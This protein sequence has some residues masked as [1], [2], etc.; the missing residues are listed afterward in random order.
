MR[1][2][3]TILRWTP[4]ASYTDGSAF[5]AADFRGYEF[6]YRPVGAVDLIPVVV[7]V[8]PLALGDTS[9]PIAQLQLPQNVELEVAMRVVAVNGQASS[10]A[11]ANDTVRF[12]ARVPSPP[13]AVSVA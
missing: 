8:I 13:S 1:L 2:N 5:G 4:P 7:L 12:D 11:F 6:A 9:V 10:Y 3:P